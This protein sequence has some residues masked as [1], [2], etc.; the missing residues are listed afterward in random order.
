VEYL[1]L[2]QT[3]SEEEIFPLAKNQTILL[4]SFEKLVQLMHDSIIN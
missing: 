3:V 4:I 2:L 1:P